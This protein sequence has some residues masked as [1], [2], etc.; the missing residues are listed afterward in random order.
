MQPSFQT[1]DTYFDFGI[2][3]SEYVKLGD[4]AGIQEARAFAE[5]YSTGF[6]NGDTRIK[7][8][9]TVRRGQYGRSGAEVELASSPVRTPRNATSALVKLGSQ[10]LGPVNI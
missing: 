6:E 8:R 7:C 3:I 10:I 4:T 2:G 1:S 9:C 5:D